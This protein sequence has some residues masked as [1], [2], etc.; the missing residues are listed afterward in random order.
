MESIKISA[1]GTVT[2]G[3]YDEI[4]VSGSGKIK[5]ETK[6]NLLRASGALSCDNNI[7]AKELKVSG[8]TK[9]EGNLK[10]EDGR[11]N[12]AIRIEGDLEANKFEANGSIIVGGDVNVDEFIAKI[13]NGSFENIYGDKIHI[14]SDGAFNCIFF[15]E[16]VKNIKVENI[17]ATTI[18]VNDIKAE[19]VSGDIVCIEG[20]CNI[21]LVEYRK[22]LDI[23]SKAKIGLIV[24]L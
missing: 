3:V 21:N 20:G 13:T 18:C 15:H 2:G 12:G 23:S 9:F 19:R 7:E 10:V 11:A 1:S 17:E 24:K 5:G 4:K 16:V 6:C 14:N 22:S 8:S